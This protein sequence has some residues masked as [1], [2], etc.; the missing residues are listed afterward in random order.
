V[1]EIGI[2][3]TLRLREL[4]FDVLIK[5]AGMGSKVGKHEVCMSKEQ[6]VSLFVVTFVFVDLCLCIRVRLFLRAML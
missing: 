1:L 4:R 6:K 5:Y 2:H 3:L